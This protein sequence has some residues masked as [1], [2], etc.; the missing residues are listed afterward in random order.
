MSK[1]V[2]LQGWVPKDEPLAFVGIVHHQ[3]NA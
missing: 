2:F 1:T 3:G